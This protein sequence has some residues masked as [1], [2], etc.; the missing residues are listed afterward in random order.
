MKSVFAII[1]ILIAQIANA[2]LDDKTKL[3]LN[4]A[5]NVVT[6]DFKDP[7]SAIFRN[8][9]LVENVGENGAIG[10]CGQVNGKNSYGGYVGFKSYVVFGNTGL[11][12]KSKIDADLIMLMCDKTNKNYKI[13]EIN[14]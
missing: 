7:A 3:A 1:I 2:E 12:N 4:N 11:I 13:I 10:V 9:Y 5:H 6:K 14:E 8:E